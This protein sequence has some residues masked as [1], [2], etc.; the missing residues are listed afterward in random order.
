[1]NSI[2]SNLLIGIETL[3]IFVFLIV[4]WKMQLHLLKILDYKYI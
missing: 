2:K 3:E 4:F 1:M